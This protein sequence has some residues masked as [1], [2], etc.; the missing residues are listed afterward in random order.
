MN[1]NAVVAADRLMAPNLRCGQSTRRWASEAL[2]HRVPRPTNKCLSHRNPAAQES[3]KSGAKV[4]PRSRRIVPSLN[5]TTLDGRL[6]LARSARLSWQGEIVNGFQS[7]CV[8]PAPGAR[9]HRWNTIRSGR[10]WAVR[11]RGCSGYV[12][13]G[14]QSSRPWA[15]HTRADSVEDIL[16]SQLRTRHNAGGV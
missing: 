1:N 7:G 3:S 16:A 12:R 14:R 9:P 15:Y 5:R 13:K 11:G 8:G 10:R 6:R 2:L 4:T